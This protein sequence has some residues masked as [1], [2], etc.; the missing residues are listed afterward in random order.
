MQCL[1]LWYCQIIQTKINQQLKRLGN[2]E[3]LTILLFNIPIE[4][5]HHTMSAMSLRE[6]D[7][8]IRLPPQTCLP[9]NFIEDIF[10]NGHNFEFYDFQRKMRIV[11]CKW[12]FWY[13]KTSHTLSFDAQIDWQF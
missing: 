11:P 3:R 13:N 2:S 8:A 9:F 6:T 1:R 5:V 7:V 10:N 12:R 4:F